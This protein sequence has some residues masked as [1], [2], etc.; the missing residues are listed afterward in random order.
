MHYL[1]LGFTLGL[2]AGITPGPLLTLV[3]AASL[4]RGL[5]GGLRVALVPFITDT[6]IVVLSLFLL[7]QLPPWALTAVAVAG[8]LL[9]IY[10]GVN[11]LR[12]ARRV[13]FLDQM[14]ELGAGGG[15][16]WQGALVNVL[17]PHPYLFWATVGGPTLLAGWQ[18][19]AMN[20]VLFLLSFY[21]LLVGS[22]AV[23]AWLVAR[24]RRALTP[25]GYRRVLTVCGA[26]MIALGLM[27][28]RGAW[29]A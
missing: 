25:A 28:I 22:Q 24:Q 5:S 15:E 17:N 16:L 1:I 7:H 3:I 6:P 4:R 2:S 12:A 11:T 19:S 14:G 26:V 10:L 9:V 13:Q 18:Q 23:V 20:A 27:L 29:M 21:A 8:G